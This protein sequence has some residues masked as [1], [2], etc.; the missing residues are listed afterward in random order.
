MEDL[1]T[2]WKDAEFHF[3]HPE[4]ANKVGRYCHAKD[5]ECV[6]DHDNGDLNCIHQAPKEVGEL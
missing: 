1:K 4:Y 3:P 2:G 6:A 5:K